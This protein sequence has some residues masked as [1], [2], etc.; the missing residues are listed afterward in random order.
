MDIYENTLHIVLYVLHTAQNWHMRLYRTGGLRLY[1]AL[2]NI[3]LS[4]VQFN[5][6]F[7][8]TRIAMFLMNRDSIFLGIFRMGNLIFAFDII[9]R[10]SAHPYVS[11]Q[12]EYNIWWCVVRPIPNLSIEFPCAKLWQALRAYRRAGHNLLLALRIGGRRTALRALLR[13]DAQRHRAF[14]D[15]F[16]NVSYPD[17]SV[18][19][20]ECLDHYMQYTPDVDHRTLCRALKVD[21]VYIWYNSPIDYTTRDRWTLDHV[22]DC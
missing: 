16:W 8:N 1:A 19:Y 6:E 3:T 13:S 7:C 14:R 15:Q 18:T 4:A 20:N 5:F 17:Y 11:A 22:L 21:N 9:K 12:R 10:R 2:Q